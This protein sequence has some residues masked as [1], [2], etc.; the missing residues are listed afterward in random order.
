MSPKIPIG[1]LIWVK[2]AMKDMDLARASHL[3][4][5]VMGAYHGA[6]EW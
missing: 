3:C 5:L 2:F 4:L 1:L 6:L